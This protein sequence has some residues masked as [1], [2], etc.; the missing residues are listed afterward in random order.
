MWHAD[1]NA[2]SVNMPLVA[3]ANSLLPIALPESSAAGVHIQT[4]LRIKIWGLETEGRREASQTAAWGLHR[5]PNSSCVHIGLPCGCVP[6][7]NMRDV[8]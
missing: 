4:V 2:T 3:S 5:A 7:C 1:E 6:P 8:N